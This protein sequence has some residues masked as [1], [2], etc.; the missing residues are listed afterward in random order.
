LSTEK[1]PRAP[2][3]KAEPKITAEQRR[4]WRILPLADWNVMTFLAYFA[5]MN[6]ELYGAETYLPMRNY[7][8][9]QGALKRAITLH[10]PEVLREACD[11]AFRTY[12]PTR[13]Y[14][15]LTA[16]FAISYR[17]NAIIPAILARKADDERRASELQADNGT[18]YERR[19]TALSALL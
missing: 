6:A 5:G 18:D 19:I 10:G 4:D 12:K 3:K 2:R 14:P 1:K 7:A 9:E 16:G 15:L 17:I 11:E 8:F 13:D